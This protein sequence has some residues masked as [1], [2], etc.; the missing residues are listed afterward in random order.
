[1]KQKYCVVCGAPTKLKR[2]CSPECKKQA[3][4][5]ERECEYCGAAFIPGGKQRTYAIYR[6]CSKRCADLDKGCGACE[7]GRGAITQHP[8]VSML[9]ADGSTF[10]SQLHLCDECNKELEK[11]Q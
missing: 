11:T 10:I 8:L 1:M 6:Y 3:S 7:C 5:L 4:R 2:Y 9:N